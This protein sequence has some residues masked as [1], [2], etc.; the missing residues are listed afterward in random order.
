MESGVKLLDPTDVQILAILQQD[1]RITNAD[2]AKKVG[3]SPPTVLQRVRILEK[4]GLIKN[5]VA[6][7][8]AERLG[9]KTTVFAMISLSMHQDQ[10]IERFRKAVQDIEEVVECHHVSGEFDFLLKIVVKDI[11]G[12]EALIRERLSRIRGI[13]QIRSSF[14]MATNK[15]ST[16]LPL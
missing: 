9:L 7:L 11:K 16:K 15:Y 2:L 6:L 3:L 12:Y 14:V 1:G 5:Y 13:H 8:D 4:S 10:P